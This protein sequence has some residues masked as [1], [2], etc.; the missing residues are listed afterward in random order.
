QLNTEWIV[1]SLRVMLPRRFARGAGGVGGANH[2]PAQRATSEIDTGGAR[3][4]EGGVY[5]RRVLAQRWYAQWAIQRRSG[6]GSDSTM[7]FS[8]SAAIRARRFP[9]ALSA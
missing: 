8:R 1:N 7:V 5:G 6:L 2:E 3:R 4:S 9:S